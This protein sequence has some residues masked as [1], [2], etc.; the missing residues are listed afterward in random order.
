MTWTL[1]NDDRRRVRELMDM[2]HD[3]ALVRCRRERNLSPS[4][5]PSHAQVWWE[6]V[7]CQLSTQQRSGP[8][9]PIARLLQK[10]PFPLALDAVEAAEDRDA[11]VQHVLVSAGGVHRYRVLGRYLADNLNTL[12][13]GAWEDFD[14]QF[15]S[16]CPAATLQDERR[17][18][19]VVRDALLGIGPKQ[20]RNLLQGLG[21]SRFVLPIDS[22][23][24]K[25]LNGGFAPW[26]ITAKPLGDEAYYAL[27]EDMVQVLSQA[28]DVTPCEL[29]AA[30]FA[31]VD[32]DGWNEAKLVW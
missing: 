22:R 6:I 17:S 26:E 13:Q 5:A 21:L 20:S 16:L 27:V 11:M 18:A 1:T 10:D 30:V 3:N 14:K 8:D 24:V 15:Q 23:I 2:M 29:D 19:A 32:G 4:E 28:A 7:A 31:R 25:W 12:E 9:S